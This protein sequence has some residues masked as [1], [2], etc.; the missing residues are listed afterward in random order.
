ML[1]ENYIND[2]K[3]NNEKS[4]IKKIIKEYNKEVEFKLNG[5]I[6]KKPVDVYFFSILSLIGSLA[7]LY[8]KREN[9]SLLISTIYTI[10]LLI[11]SIIPIIFLRNLKKG[12][13][14]DVRLFLTLSNSIVLE[15]MVMCFTGTYMLQFALFNN[16]T[17]KDYLKMIIL[18]VILL[19]PVIIVGIRNAPK[20]FI[21][22]FSQKNTY[23]NQSEAVTWIAITLGWIANITKPYMLLLLVF[24]SCIIYFTPRFIFLV[25]KS[26]KY[27]YIQSLLK[28]KE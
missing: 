8:L 3:K 2:L 19:I 28:F 24:Y 26:T 5:P 14:L 10:P 7:P 27:D 11:L 16:W 9:V 1:V 20:K 12:K 22:Q 15:F 6:M 17:S 25:Y 23:K 13:Y 4:K 21:N 18:F